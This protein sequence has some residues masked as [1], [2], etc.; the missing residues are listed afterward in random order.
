MQEYLFLP[1]SLCPECG[2]PLADDYRIY[3]LLSVKRAHFNR[4]V[5]VACVSVE[6][7]GKDVHNP[8]SSTALNQT[9]G[10]PPGFGRLAPGAYQF[11]QESWPSS[12]DFVPCLAFHLELSE[13]DCFSRLLCRLEAVLSDLEESDSLRNAPLTP[14][15]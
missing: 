2:I 1:D 3:N 5:C 8:V 9:W 12:E 15:S 14:P 13:S 4:G 10:R 6:L 7:S 11:Q